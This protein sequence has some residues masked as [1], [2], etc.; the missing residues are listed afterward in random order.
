M[1]RTN[2]GK[3][4][5]LSNP[6]AIYVDPRSGWKWKVLKTYKHSSAERKDPYARWFL[7]SSSPWVQD[8]LG[9]GY[10]QDVLK[11]GYLLEADE[12]WVNEYGDVPLTTDYTPQT[13]M[14]IGSTLNE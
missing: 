8:E 10:I 9:D 12:A 5:T 7:A 3:S 1:P 13:P 11:Y 6:Y 2:F 4:R 14:R